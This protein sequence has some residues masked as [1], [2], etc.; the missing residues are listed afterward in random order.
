MSS[1]KRGGQRSPSDNYPTPGW[2]L[3]RFLERFLL[4]HP[5]ALDV[6]A[7][8]EPG[9]GEGNLIR[10][11]NEWFK[12]EAK[13]PEWDVNELREECLPF[14]S[15]L[16]IR[17]ITISD[18]LEN[19]DLASHPYDVVITNPPF[20]ITM[21][22][23]EASLRLNTR[24]VI[25][26]QRLNYIGTERRHAFMKANPPDLYVLPNRPS[27]QATGATDSIEYAWMVWDTQNLKRAKGEYVML[28]LT[29]KEE[30]KNDHALV[31]DLGI[32]PEPEKA[33]PPEPTQ[34]VVDALEALKTDVDGDC[35]VNSEALNDQ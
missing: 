27:F 31:Q 10:T 18:F 25:M 9:V 12:T 24:Y 26:L 1:T 5:D 4:D 34:E 6:G 32:F 15:G 35:S 2:C 17:E 19:G 11:A 16:G 13:E 7:W 29:S 22:F 23:I 3:R 8:L 33:S 21:Q 14:L 30:R 20:S 28:E